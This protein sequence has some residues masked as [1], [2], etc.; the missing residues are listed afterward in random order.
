MSHRKTTLFYAVL[1]AVASAAVGMVIASRLDLSSHSSA[2]TVALP[3]ANSTPLGGPI[4]ATTFRTIAKAQ[5]PTVVNI[6]TEQRRRTRE[7]TEFFGGDEF[8]ERFFGRPSRPRGD[9]DG[10]EQITEGAGSGFIVD[11]EG[12]ILTNNHV[13]EGASKITVSLFGGGFNEEY[14][15]TVVGRDQLTDSALIKLERR[16][17][18]PLAVAKFGDSAQLEPGDWVMAIGNPFGLDHTVTVGVVSALARPFGGT[19][20][21]AQ[22]ML[23][24]D[25]AINPGNSGGPLLNIRG[26]V[27]G[28]NTAIFTDQRA[29]NLGIGFAMPINTIRELLPQLRT[30]K[31]IR[32]RI[33]VQ[34]ATQPLTKS[35]AE[36][37]GLPGAE[38]AVV[39]IVT[40]GGPAAKA[41]L[42]PGD[43]I[44]EYNGEP[45]KDSAE[46]VAKV[47]QTKPGTTVRLTVYRNKKPQTVNVTIEELNL[48]E[49]LGIRAGRTPQQQED[50][51][52]ETGLGLELAPI[53]PEIARRLR[54]PNN[55]G[56]A[57][58]ARVERNSAAQAAGVA[59]NDVILEVNQRPV[60]NMNDL[61]RE[62]QRMQSGD[63]IFLL[64][65]RLTPQGGQEVFITVTNP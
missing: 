21:R 6:R 7:L 9:Q 38:G 39:S 58:V 1:I 5:M 49:E 44:T 64:V 45:V 43:V 18:G 11:P 65:W 55:R 16:P 24:T 19:P 31:V 26:E 36:A 22:D 53:T 63:T 28:I 48:D 33:G 32:G 47:V 25:A 2:Q 42:R 35:V 14:P 62:L 29:A 17:D 15:A 27:V 4:D 51:R 30:G 41:G 12:Y 61:R 20:G 56:G 10:G 59:P 46:L 52:M 3:P 13:V 37:H 57:I 23:Q 8:F 50:E 40:E 54:L 34:V 60:A